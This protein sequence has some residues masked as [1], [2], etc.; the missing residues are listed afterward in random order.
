[1]SKILTTLQRQLTEHYDAQKFSHRHILFLF[2]FLKVFYKVTKSQKKIYLLCKSNEEVHTVLYHTKDIKGRRGLKGSRRPTKPSDLLQFEEAA[3]LCKQP[4]LLSL[5]R[6][7]PGLKRLA[8]DSF[9][10]TG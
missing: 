4:Q 5:N 7:R 3:R 10:M 2:L 6:Q 1:M 8:E 9:V